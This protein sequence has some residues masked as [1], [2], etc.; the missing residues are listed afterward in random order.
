MTYHEIDKYSTTLAQNLRQIG[1]KRRENIGFCFEKSAWAIISMLGILKAGGSCV[2]LDPSHPPSRIRTILEA[3]SLSTVLVEARN[4]LLAQIQDLTL[5][6]VNRSFF[7]TTS[8]QQSPSQT[9]PFQQGSRPTDPAFILFTSGSTG[10]PKAVVL[11]HSAICS[12]A[13]YHGK[14]MFVGV[15]SRV[16][17]HAAYTFDMSIYDIF[18]TLILGGTVCIP[19]SYSRIH[20]IAESIQHL[21]ANWAFFTPTLLSTLHPNEVSGL[22]TVLL[23]G[24]PVT[25]EIID[26]WAAKVRLLNGYGSTEMSTCF[27]AHLTPS[28]DP[29][30]IGTPKGVITRIVDPET[31]CQI[32]DTGAG[33]LVV[34][35]P[36]LASGYLNDCNRTN[37]SF[38]NFSSKS[39][40]YRIYRTGDI[41]ERNAD[42]SYHFLG[43]RD[44]MTWHV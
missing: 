5:V 43:R 29:R 31:L 9:L 40:E 7:S 26:S 6:F 4:D 20:R 12:S 14:A 36:V 33:E 18:T 38:L 15:E 22:R 19:S 32:M 13:K 42:G 30:N 8:N 2:P 3:A 1:I 27:L 41:V 28:S 35:G 17:Q 25:Q 10:S 21:R 37:T 44:T 39:S 11:T 34:I 23:A 16:Y 24:E